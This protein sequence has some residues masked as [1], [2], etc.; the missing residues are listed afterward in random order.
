MRPKPFI[1]PPSAG[2]IDVRFRFQKALIYAQAGLQNTAMQ[3]DLPGNT[4]MEQVP[5][6]P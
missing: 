6:T 3:P 1:R 4:G 5:Y 2:Q